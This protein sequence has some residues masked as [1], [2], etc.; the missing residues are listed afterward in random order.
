LP[1]DPLNAVML[2]SSRARRVEGAAKHVSGPAFALAQNAPGA[3]SA[4]PTGQKPPE[5]FVK[6]EAMVLRSFIQS[7]LPSDAGAVYGGGLAG[8]MWKS[9][10]AEE[11]AEVLAKSGG[12]GIAGGLLKDSYESAQGLAP[13]RGAAGLLSP[14][15]LLEIATAS[16]NQD[17]AA[18]ALPAAR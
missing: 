5:T 18:A 8:D 17:L 12:I 6:F 16:M 4:G 10:L 15:R 13:E 7:M 2:N 3:S 11:V 14:S 1:I 9:L